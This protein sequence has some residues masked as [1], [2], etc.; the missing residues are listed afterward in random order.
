MRNQRASLVD[1]HHSTIADH[2]GRQYRGKTTLG[3]FFCHAVFLPVKGV[4]T[5]FY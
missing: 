5:T 3:V 2:V 4:V 1:F